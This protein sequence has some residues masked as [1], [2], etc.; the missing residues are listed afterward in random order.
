MSD[1]TIDRNY[2]SLSEALV[3]QTERLNQTGQTTTAS[4][5]TVPT[6]SFQ[7]LLNQTLNQTQTQSVSFSKHANMR[8]LERNI[9]V[10]EA[11]LDKLGTACE[12]ACEKGIKDALIMMDDSAFIVNAPNKVV[13]T[14]VDKTEMKENVITNIDGAI[15]L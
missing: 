15:F 8:A 5:K 11:D 10:S 7:D 1:S 12:K 2:I 6:T 9:E 4:Q 13:I 3:R 14:V